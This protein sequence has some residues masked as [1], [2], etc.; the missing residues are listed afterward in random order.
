MIGNGAYQNTTQL[1]S[2]K[3]DAADMAA[4]LTR[5]GFDVVDGSDLDKRAMER[6][7]RAFTQKLSHATLR[8]STSPVM[9]CRAEAR[10][11]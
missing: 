5:L 8:S 3:S 10:T 9:P 7:M 2:T 1:K 11:F 4:A 6:T